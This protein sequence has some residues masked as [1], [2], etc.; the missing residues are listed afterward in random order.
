MRAKFF[1]RKWLAKN[2]QSIFI[3]LI[4]IPGTSFGGLPVGIRAIDSRPTCA[5]PDEH[6]LHSNR[7]FCT[8]WVNKGQDKY[9]ARFNREGLRGPEYST[10]F[11]GNRILLSGGSLILGPGLSEGN[12]I[13]SVVESEL[14][15]AKLK[16]AEV[17]NGGVAGFC[18]MQV[19]VMLPRL[20]AAYMPKSF[21]YLA[22]FTDGLIKDNLYMQTTEFE[23]GY[24][25]TI[26][27]LPASFIDRFLGVQY[28]D[29]FKIYNTLSFFGRRMV[30]SWRCKIRSKSKLDL[31]DCLA[32]PTVALIKKMRI[33]SESQNIKFI[34]LLQRHTID[35]SVN[36]SP[37]WYYSLANFI[38]F[39]TPKV[40]VSAEFL[41]EYLKAKGFQPIEIGALSLL[42]E[43][44]HLKD[45]FHLNEKGSAMAGIEIAQKLLPLLKQ[46]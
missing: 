22:D 30:V 9:F 19:A 39:F 46:K 45:D 33:L 3:G 16:K 11:K 32:G 21:V 5:Q 27:L 23:N 28:G 41:P 26:H 17:L 31:A 40:Q 35:N 29:L 7:P 14:R 2:A 36:L 18:T 20:F 8:E 25:T 4:F 1:T 10:K 43:K 37:Y 6:T 24:P 38:D 13:P 44:L 42:D 12:T 34:L 15:K